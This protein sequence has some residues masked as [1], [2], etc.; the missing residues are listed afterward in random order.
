MSGKKISFTGGFGGK[1][2]TQIKLPITPS[3]VKWSAPKANKKRLT[4]TH[5]YPFNTIPTHFHMR[6]SVVGFENYKELSALI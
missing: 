3:K 2:S 4:Q 1:I 5:T 6:S